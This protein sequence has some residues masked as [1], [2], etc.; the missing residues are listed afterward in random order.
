MDL[1]NI[2]PILERCPAGTKLYCPLLGEVSFI[3]VNDCIYNNNSNKIIC[4]TKEGFEYSF[5][6]YG[7]YFISYPNAECMLFP[8]KENRDWNTFKVDLSV[9]TIV[10]VSDYVSSLGVEKCYIKRY[11]GNHCCFSNGKSSRNC[12]TAVGWK[13]IVPLDK[14]NIRNNEISFNPK[15]NYGTETSC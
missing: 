10:L 6:L 4:G 9:D 3:R 1:I 12:N 7:Q 8:S 13:T 2:A 5:N 15:D 14:I 11:A